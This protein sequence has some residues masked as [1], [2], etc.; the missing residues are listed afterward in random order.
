MKN[1][2]SEIPN[3]KQISNSQITSSKQYDLN[4]EH[5]EISP[6]TKFEKLGFR[7]CLEFSAWNFGFNILCEE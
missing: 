2:K 1:S 6:F 5:N 4:E 3:S 7:D